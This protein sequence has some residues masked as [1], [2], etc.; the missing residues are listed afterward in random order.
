[1]CPCL[2]CHKPN[3]HTSRRMYNV[4]DVQVAGVAMLDVKRGVKSLKIIIIIIIR[5]ISVNILTM[6]NALPTSNSK[7]SKI[8]NSVAV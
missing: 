2:S 3:T 6:I 7:K 4:Y 1:M 8:I 5:K